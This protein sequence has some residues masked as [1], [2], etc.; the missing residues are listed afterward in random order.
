M[1]KYAAMAT[2]TAIRPSWRGIVGRHAENRSGSLYDDDDPPPTAQVSHPV[3]FG[4][5]ECLTLCERYTRGGIRIQ[6][7]NEDKDS[8]EKQNDMMVS[9]FRVYHMLK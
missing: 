7:T 9:S 6:R 1:K 8:G 5:G 4:K 2:M 3:H